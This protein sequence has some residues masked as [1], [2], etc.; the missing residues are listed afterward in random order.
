MDAVHKHPGFGILVTGYSLGAG[1]G[2]L[3]TMDLVE[4]QAAHCLPC[5]VQIRC[6]TYGAPPVFASDREPI[7]WNFF[8]AKKGGGGQI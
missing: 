1:I 6:I 7:L 8:S 5:T 4:G 3:V 2:H